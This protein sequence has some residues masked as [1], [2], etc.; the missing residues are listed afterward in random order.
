MLA[1]RLGPA[2]E[3][4]ELVELRMRGEHVVGLVEGLHRDFPVAVEVQP[5][6]PLVA[7]VLQTERVEDLRRRKEIVGQRFAVGIHV[8]EKPATPGVDLYRGEVGI[9]GSQHALPVVLL[10][11]VRARAVQSVCP[12]V[13]SAHE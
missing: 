10:A 12:A 8:D 9:R 7:H 13:E 11:N 5:L 2:L 6:A 1:L 4:A 3:L